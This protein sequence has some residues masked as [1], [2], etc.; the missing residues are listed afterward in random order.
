MRYVEVAGVRLSAIGLGTWQFG[1]RD[2]GYGDSYANE[3]AIAITHRAL[4]LGIN[5]FDTA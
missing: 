3:T 5:F 4:E 1:S 2:W